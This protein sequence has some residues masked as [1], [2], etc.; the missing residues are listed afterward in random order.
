[1]GLPPSLWEH[2]LGKWGGPNVKEAKWT[3]KDQRRKA[4]VY[5]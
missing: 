2:Y 1:M 4:Q 3:T 5:R